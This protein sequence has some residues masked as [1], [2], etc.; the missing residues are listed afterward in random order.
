MIFFLSALPFAAVDPR[1]LPPLEDVRDR[2]RAV[3][4]PLVLASA[5][6]QHDAIE[7]V[8]PWTREGLE[9]ALQ[10]ALVAELGP[11]AEG[12]FWN[13]SEPG[14]GGPVRAYCCEQHSLFVGEAPR[15]A[16]AAVSVLAALEEWRTL[17]DELG[18]RFKILRD[19]HE[20]ADV[21]ARVIAAAGELLPLVLARTDATDAWYSTFSVVLTWF[22][23]SCGYERATVAPVIAE[24]VSGRFASW[25][26]PSVEVAGPAVRTLGAL[27]SAAVSAPPSRVEDALAR[28]TETRA[29]FASNAVTR[30]ELPVSWDG[31]RRFVEGPETTRDPDRAARFSSALEAC[32]DSARAKEPLDFA[33]LARWQSIVLGH[34]APF[35]EGEA[36]AKGG[37]ERYGLDDQTRARFEG[38]LAAANDLSTPF[39]TRAARVYLDICFTHPFADGNARS[40][41]LALDYVLTGEGRWLRNVEPL[42]LLARSPSDTDS[43]RHLAWSIGFLSGPSEG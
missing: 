8:A 7:P 41:R 30:D 40:A 6:G 12:M 11:W 13:A 27:V 1:H 18:Q 24:V 43:T 28:W 16:N 2:A 35:R 26:T 4:A 5:G 21:E 20:T 34:A 23:E 37:R 29:R 42:F 36:F 33:S 22:A 15:V 10:Q 9:T 17:L 19:A 39:A 38:W 3:I 31:H 32:R 25:I 14:G